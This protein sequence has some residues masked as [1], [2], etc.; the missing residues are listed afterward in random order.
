MS[1]DDLLVQAKS[2]LRLEA[3][4]ILE[5]A[6][7]LDE[8]FCR[9]IGMILDCR[10]RV[11]VT[12]MGKSGLIGRKIAATL[13]STGTPAFFLHPAEGSHGDIG[14]IAK[15]DLMVVLS[16]SGETCEVVAIL[17]VVKRLGI[18]LIAILGRC[19]ST[20]A[21]LSDVILDVSVA[22]EACPMGLAPTC[23]TTAALAMGD[24]LAVVLL[25]RRHFKPE[26][27]AMLHP[28]GTIGR[29]LLLRVA[30]VMHVGQAIPVVQAN[31]SV[32]KALMEMTSKRL[33]MTGVLDEQGLL[34][35]IVTDGDLRRYLER[36]D[37]LLSRMVLE[38]MTTHPK[39]IT[40]EALA[41]EAL[42]R[43]EESK[44]TTL[45]VVDP[46]GK[47]TGVIHLHD[48]LSAGLT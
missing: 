16:N 47:L 19:D 31:D 46:I 24:A 38:I 6:E 26:Q 43:M 9:A 7:R 18:P 39:K 35:G 5:M 11:I 14:M 17:P 10:G 34:I 40:Q 23:S 2:A 22:R 41:V 30:D 4:A 48:L 29:R 8:Q 42:H 32:R 33:G 36:D 27:F 25:E 1:E 21:R 20:L 13:S 37:H 12:G 44:I 15:Q 28:G 45:F 3:Q